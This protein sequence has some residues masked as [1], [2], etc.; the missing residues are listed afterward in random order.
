MTVV[1]VGY[2][3]QIGIILDAI[4]GKTLIQNIPFILNY[5][6]LQIYINYSCVCYYTYTYTYQL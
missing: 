2:L 6:F 3:A 1:T 5:Y 4:L